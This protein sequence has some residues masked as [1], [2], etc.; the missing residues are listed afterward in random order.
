MIVYKGANVPAREQCHL[1]REPCIAEL[2][3]C[4]HVRFCTTCDSGSNESA[5]ELPLQEPAAR[6]VR[7]QPYLM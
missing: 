3:T 1:T 7:K 6:V 4:V 5:S 2:R